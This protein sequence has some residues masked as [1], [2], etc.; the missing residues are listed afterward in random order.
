MRFRLLRSARAG[1][2]IDGLDASIL[3]RII[4]RLE[5]L[6][7]D[8]YSRAKMLRGEHG[9][10][11]CRVGDWRILYSVDAIAG[12]VIVDRVQHRREVYRDI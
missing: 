8:P 2:D 9:L 4:S 10:W 6:E 12:L 5:S 11:T 1:R 3:P 7:E